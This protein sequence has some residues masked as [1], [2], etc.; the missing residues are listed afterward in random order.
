[1][2]VGMNSPIQGLSRPRSQHG[3]IW[4]WAKTRFLVHRWSLPVSSPWQRRERA[5]WGLFQKS[6]TPQSSS[7]DHPAPRRPLLWE[8]AFNIVCKGHIQSLNSYYSVGFSL[9]RL[10]TPGHKSLLLHL[11]VF[12]KVKSDTQ[13]A[14]WLN[15]E[16]IRTVRENYA[17]YTAPTQDLRSDPAWVK[18]TSVKSQNR[19]ASCPANGTAAEAFDSIK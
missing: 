2:T 19:H 14:C 11:L 7:P 15:Y 4:Q 13:Q 9:G 12:L 16:L 18:F 3:K 1:M 17:K 8:L 10:L 6:T 5:F